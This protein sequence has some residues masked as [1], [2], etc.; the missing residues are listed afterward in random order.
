MITVF[1]YGL[2]YLVRNIITDKVYIGKT[3][4]A[5]DKRKKR[6]I[7]ESKNNLTTMPFHKALN[8]YGVESFV[9]E[10]LVWCSS[11]EV[12]N[13]MENY[14]IGKYNAY[15]EDGY[16]AT[17]G[18]DGGG[19]I[20]WTEERRL[21]ARE[22]YKNSE[23]FKT[24]IGESHPMYGKHHTEETK[25]KLS[26]A[27]SG[28]Q[29]P[30][31]GT[32][33]SDE[34][35]LK[36]CGLNKGQSMSCEQKKKI[37]ETRKSRGSS[38]GCNNNMYGLVGE[39]SPTSKKYVITSPNGSIFIIKGLRKFCR[40]VFGPPGDASGMS[41]CAK[42]KYKQYKGYSCRYFIEDYDANLKEFGYINQ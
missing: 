16:N 7:Y 17:C 29:N 34:H 22:R 13:E 3:T 41:A 19:G 38:S 40:D 31:F 18:G 10:E 8:K 27:L 42:G 11:L 26:K 6:H 14:Y 33:L 2:I 9:W 39:Y 21:K 1:N 35:K 23:F 20:V 24:M 15:G 30:K 28:E 5:L 37:S 4:K 12:L 36:F 32:K 25:A